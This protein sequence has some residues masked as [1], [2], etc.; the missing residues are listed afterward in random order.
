[1]KKETQKSPIPQMNPYIFTIL[2]FGFGLWCIRDGWFNPDPNYEHALFNQVIGVPLFCWGI[3]D[4]IKL[5][6]NKKK[7]KNSDD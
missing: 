1:V 4:L 3:Y 7:K 5:R 6:K 2:L